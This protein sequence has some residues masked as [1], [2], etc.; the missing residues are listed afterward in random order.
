MGVPWRVKFVPSEIFLSQEPHRTNW[1]SWGQ[2]I[3]YSGFVRLWF[4]LQV[5]SESN[6][7][8][9]NWW[10]VLFIGWQIRLG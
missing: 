2:G 8:G 6:S 1:L 9:G 5:G 10:G 7:V 3:G 4:S